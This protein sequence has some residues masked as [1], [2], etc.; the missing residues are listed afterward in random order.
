MKAFVEGYAQASDKVN[1]S[2][3]FGQGGNDSAVRK[4]ERS[5]GQSMFCG[6]GHEPDS[7]KP[8]P[9]MLY[10][11]GGRCSGG[12]IPGLRSGVGALEHPVPAY[13][14]LWFPG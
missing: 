1:A 9:P 12:Q 7:G 11:W 4:E 2:L 8:A 6:I 3:A 13:F 14:E 10:A 5:W